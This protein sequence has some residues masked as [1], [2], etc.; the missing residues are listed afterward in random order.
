MRLPSGS[1]ETITS[2]AG[3]IRPLRGR[4]FV[5]ARLAAADADEWAGHDPDLR[6]L[7]DLGGLKVARESQT[8]TE[9]RD[10]LL[11]ML[12]NGQIQI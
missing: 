7:K 2:M 3:K 9:L 6:G 5:Q 10:W 11:P 4:M 12:M 8:L 1:R